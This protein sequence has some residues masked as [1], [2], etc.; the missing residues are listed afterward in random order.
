[1]GW[2]RLQTANCKEGSMLSVSSPA[3]PFLGVGYFT[4]NR[5]AIHCCVRAWRLAITNHRFGLRTSFTHPQNSSRPN[6]RIPSRHYLTRLPFL[7]HR[8][9]RHIE[10]N[11]LVCSSPYP[12]PFSLAHTQDVASTVCAQFS[13]SPH[14]SATLDH[15]VFVFFPRT[16][17]WKAAT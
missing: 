7:V 17:S 5:R 3:N 6:R 13:R 12:R 1:M 14:R 9:F 10:P 2:Y 4:T 15:V 8:R 16:P 11:Q